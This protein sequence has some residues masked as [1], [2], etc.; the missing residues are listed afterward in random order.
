MKTIGTDILW[1]QVA[2]I[3]NRKYFPMTS[4]IGSANSTFKKQKMWYVKEYTSYSS[5]VNSQYKT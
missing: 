3:H 5:E 4:N 1:H 2:L